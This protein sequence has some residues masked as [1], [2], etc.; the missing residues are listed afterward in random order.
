MSVLELDPNAEVR[1]RKWQDFVPKFVR[2]IRDEPPAPPPRPAAERVVTQDL[3]EAQASLATLQTAG[4]AIRARCLAD[5]DLAILSENYAP[6]AAKAFLAR[7]AD[8]V[9]RCLRDAA[10]GPGLT[11]LQCGDIGRID[12]A[13]HG[14]DRERLGAIEAQGRVVADLTDAAANSRYTNV[15]APRLRAADIKVAKAVLM[16][17]DAWQARVALAEAARRDGGP[18]VIS[19]PALPRIGDQ[20]RAIIRQIGS[21][22]RPEDLL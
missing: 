5:P 17:R 16:L 18:V 2:V 11:I 13:L 4:V 19:T 15:H 21:A 20:L 8:D 10:A 6:G 3:A 12:R 22:K 1:N 7:W 9:A 14:I